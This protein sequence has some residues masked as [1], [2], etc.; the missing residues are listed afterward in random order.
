M[1][2]KFNHKEDEQNSVLEKD[3]SDVTM[4]GTGIRDWR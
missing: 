2:L 4:L 1:T 3:S